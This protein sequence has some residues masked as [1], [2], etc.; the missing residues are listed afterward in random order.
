MDKKILILCND[1]SYHFEAISDRID[2]LKIPFDVKF[3][4]NAEHAL[5]LVPKHGH[6][7]IVTEILIP[8]ENFDKKT[9]AALNLAKQAR[10]KNKK[11]YVILFTVSP[12]FLEKND[13]EKFNRVI[14]STG[15]NSLEFLFVKLK[16]LS[17]GIWTA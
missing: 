9:G 6:C 15:H 3:A 16:E 17:K 8:G 2:F 5:S 13:A 7:T 14:D 4:T 12:I 1:P 11:C 10:E